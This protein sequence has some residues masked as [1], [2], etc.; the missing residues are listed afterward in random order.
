[1]RL[2]E[3]S[4]TLNINR[5]LNLNDWKTRIDL[6]EGGHG[7]TLISSTNAGK[8]KGTPEGSTI[9]DIVAVKGKIS[10]LIENK[11]GFDHCDFLKQNKHRE[12]K[13]YEDSL[14]KYTGGD[15]TAV[16]YYGIGMFDS[17]KELVKASKHFDLVDFVIETDEQGNCRIAHQI[18]QASFA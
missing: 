18:L 6:P 14:K 3:R 8:S 1:M 15:S 7:L 13:E 9:P 10:L 12:S 2:R 17:P 4:V 16:F 11:V 5:W